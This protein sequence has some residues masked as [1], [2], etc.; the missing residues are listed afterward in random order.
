MFEHLEPRRL[1]AAGELD[2][3]FGVG[4]RTTFTFDDGRVVGAQPG[5][6]IVVQEYDR[7][8]WHASNLHRL[9]PLGAPDATFQDAAPKFPRTFWGGRAEVN[10]LDGRVA[11]T[12]AGQGLSTIHVL[13]ADGAPDE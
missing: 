9:D 12:S 3:S 7:F 4:G 2:P 11:Y 6:A 1:M 5:G 8:N 10:P 13:R